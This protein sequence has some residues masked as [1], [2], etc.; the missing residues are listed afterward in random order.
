[1]SQ[2]KA[3]LIDGKSAEI[4]FTGGSASGPAISFTG[5]SNTGIYSPGADQVAVAT[6]GT[7]KARLDASGRL[8]VGTSS[9]SL[10][11]KFLLQ[12]DTSSASNGGYMRLQTANSII[13]D[14]S[15]GSIGFGDSANN[16]ALIEAKGD[17]SWS[18]FT[19]GSRLEFSTTADGAS[20]PTER[21]RIT[22]AG[23][24]GIGTSSPAELLQVG[25]FSGSNGI[26]VGAGSSN[27]SYIYFADG[28]A[29][30]EAYR[31]YLQYNHA[32]DK[33]ELGSAGLTAVTV[34]LLQR[35]GIGT[36]S[37]A[38][39]LHCAS[40]GDNN[41][42]VVANGATA[43]F[44]V[45]VGVPFVGTNNGP[46]NFYSNGQIRATLDS[47]GRL[48]IGTSTARTNFYNTTYSSQFQVEGDASATAQ[49]S[50]TS[51][52]A[53]INGPNLI[54]GK[55]RSG[56]SGGNAIVQNNDQLGTLAFMGSD[57]SEQVAGALIEA[58]VDGTPGANDMPGRLVFSTTADGASSATERMRLDSA[59]SMVLASG[60]AFVAPYVYSTTTAT[61]ANVNVDATGFLRRSTSS[62]KYKNQQLRRYLRHQAEGEHC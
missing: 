43:Q 9:A 52:F 50:L 13:A 48:L 42:R 58:F 14:T 29:G 59:G 15:L 51:T 10:T 56:S 17:V 6:G 23:L 38:S 37:P 32:T 30:T 28:T 26:T 4:E 8:L 39:I 34:D 33:L 22:S 45:D 35:V 18:P 7:E 55:H 57:G 3:Q 2:T 49:I 40:T 11:N 44:G 61:A 54:F 31:G 27:Y 12:G 24:V 20:S 53:G 46:F 62:I 41:I 19:K 1:M 47:S 5:D 21:L 25:G 60:T 16:G 36:T